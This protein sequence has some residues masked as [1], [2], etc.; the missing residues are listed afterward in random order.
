[1]EVGG[2]SLFELALA[3]PILIVFI[4]PT[5]GWDHHDWGIGSPGEF[6]EPLHNGL[7]THCSTD[8]Y[9]CTVFRSN[10]LCGGRKVK[11]Q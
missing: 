5:G 3:S 1:M 11:S 8:N 4:G 2:A 7:I 10:L 9:Q 6:E